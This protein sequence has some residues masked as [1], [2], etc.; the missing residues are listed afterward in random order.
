MHRGANVRPPLCIFL[1]ATN[2]VPVMYTFNNKI[3]LHQRYYNISYSITL[4]GEVLRQKTKW[5]E[6]DVLKKS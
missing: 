3:V 4:S 1:A 2:L 5:E 6:N